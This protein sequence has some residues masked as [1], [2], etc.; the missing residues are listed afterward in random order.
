MIIFFIFA[1][2]AAK[3]L[4]LTSMFFCGIFWAN[5]RGGIAKYRFNEVFE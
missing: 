2:L 5:F 1:D 3:S 4:N